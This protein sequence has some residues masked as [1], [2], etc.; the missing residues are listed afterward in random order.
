MSLTLGKSQSK[1][2]G[3]FAD[4]GSQGDIIKQETETLMGTSVE[5]MNA[6][7]MHRELSVGHARSPAVAQIS[8]IPEVPVFACGISSLACLGF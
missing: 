4:A 8:N 3:L 6:A 7:G 2:D 1:G 5:L